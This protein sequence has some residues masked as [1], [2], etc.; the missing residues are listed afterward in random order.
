MQ[1]ICIKQNK[2]LNI[3]MKSLNILTRNCLFYYVDN[4]VHHYTSSI[5]CSNLLEQIPNAEEFNKLSIVIYN[6]LTSISG[7]ERFTNLRELTILSNSISD[8]SLLSKLKYLTKLNLSEIL[9]DSI[10]FIENLANL[11]SFSLVGFNYD[12]SKPLSLKPI[13][14]L[15]KK[16][17]KL[18][19]FDLRVNLYPNST[20]PDYIFSDDHKVNLYKMFQDESYDADVASHKNYRNRLIYAR[21]LI[22]SLIIKN[23]IKYYWDRFLEAKKDSIS[24]YCF[25][26]N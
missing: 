1:L 19:S 5:E 26:S 14:R 6:K 12:K 11:K 23:K 8:L 3:I 13:R 7:I 25:L 22:L 4:V 10:K 24:R 2:V 16:Y 15:I 20:Y 9:V 21:K 18:E 17:G